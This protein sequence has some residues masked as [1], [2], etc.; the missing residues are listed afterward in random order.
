[1]KAH[2]TNNGVLVVTAETIPEMSALRRWS[3]NYYTNN[4]SSALA[5]A[6]EVNRYSET[7]ICSGEFNKDGE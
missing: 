4:P 3:K 6:Q 2:L 7:Y 5:L 1:M